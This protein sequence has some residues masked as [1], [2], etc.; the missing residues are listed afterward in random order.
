MDVQVSKVTESAEIMAL[1]QP[2]HD[3]NAL[4]WRGWHRGGRYVQYTVVTAASH[5]YPTF[6]ILKKKK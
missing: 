1:F 6:L 5:F 3:D 2:L 4:N